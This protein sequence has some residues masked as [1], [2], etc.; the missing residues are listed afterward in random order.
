M[1]GY[2]TKQ[3]D[4]VDHICWRFYGD[5][6]AVQRVLEANPGLADRGTTLP[7]GLV[8]ELPKRTEK[9]KPATVRLWD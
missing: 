6:L 1:A 2:R 7:G 8:I 9:T 3:G 5:T 4:T